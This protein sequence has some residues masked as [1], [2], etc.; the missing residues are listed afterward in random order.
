MNLCIHLVKYHSLGERSFRVLPGQYYDQE[1]GLYYNW[2]RYYDPKAGRYISSDPIGLRGGLNTY[3]YVANN[4]LRW[5][6]PRGTNLTAVWGAEI[7]SAFGPVGTVVGGAVGF[8]LGLWIGNEIFA[9]PPE[10]AY[11][12]NGPK[13]PGRP[14]PEEGFED[15]KGGE[16]WVPNPN[17]GKGGSR[18]GWQDDKGRVWCPTGPRPGRA[19]GGPHW[20][21]Q[22]PN[23]SNVNV[24]PGQNINDLL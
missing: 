17:P 6:D 12:P 9:K 5:I 24:R 13:A 16:N 20:D 23:G 3:T 1:T 8:G 21:V 14:G 4:P 15:P 18:H 22:L 19:H 11:D 2:H 7:G 10:N